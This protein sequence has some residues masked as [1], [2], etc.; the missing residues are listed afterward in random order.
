MK[1]FSNSYK[2]SL[3][4][5]V[6]PLCVL[7]STAE[8][9]VWSRTNP[10]TSEVEIHIQDNRGIDE[11]TI[12]NPATKNVEEK[13][14]GGCQT[15]LIVPLGLFIDHDHTHFID[16]DPCDESPAQ[17]LMTHFY[18]VVRDGDPWV[19][20]VPRE[21]PALSIRLDD[22]DRDGFQDMLVA[23][24]SAGTLSVFL[25]KGDG[26]LTD[27]EVYTLKPASP[28]PVISADPVQPHKNNFSS[29]AG[30]FSGEPGD[31]SSTPATGIEF[32]WPRPQK[33]GDFF[34]QPG[35]A[36]A[37]ANIRNCNI[38]PD[39]E[40]R[41][42]VAAGKDAD[43]NAKLRCPNRCPTRHIGNLNNSCENNPVTVVVTRRYRCP[44]Q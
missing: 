44:V 35:K 19:P 41:L 28:T 42:A 37:P 39:V 1:M 22:I 16:Y 29:A 15:E 31:F 25:N 17:G 23:Q 30:S 4:G 14:F 20:A 18:P 21:K 2:L 27:A 38:P 8:A 6:L 33:C 12:S 43:A 13:N 10:T 34:D 36:R 40:L 5:V 32:D 3:T 7:A 9:A 26:S 24:E 11:Y